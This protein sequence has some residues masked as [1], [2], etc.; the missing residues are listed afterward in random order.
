MAGLSAQ[1]GYGV[2]LSRE[3]SEQKACLPPALRLEVEDLIERVVA[4]PQVA[5]G[6]RDPA[7]TLLARTPSGSAEVDYT[8]DQARRRVHVLTLRM[9]LRQTEPSSVNHAE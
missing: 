5:I 2:Q 6:N 8:V 9:P 1:R 3:V 4:A 7:D